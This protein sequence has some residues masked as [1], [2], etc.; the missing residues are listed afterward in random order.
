[1]TIEERLEQAKAIYQNACEKGFQDEE[2][3]LEHYLMLVI[4]ELSKSVD[5]YRRKKSC[6]LLVEKTRDS[7][8]SKS[9]LEVYKD[10]PADFYKPIFDLY[11][12]DTWED[13][14]ADVCI[15]LIELAMFIKEQTQLKDETFLEHLRQ[16]IAISPKDIKKYSFTEL[17]LI[18]SEKILMILKNKKIK[19]LLPSFIMEVAHNIIIIFS[20][21]FPN[22]DLEWHIKEKMKYNKIKER[23]VD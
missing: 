14:L 7:N 22:L 16:E 8:E 13:K 5:A 12:K 17:S 15:Q 3:S 21:S 23:L 11:I 4:T 9:R 10:F 2:Y 18:C 20:K 6:D 19:H 1:M